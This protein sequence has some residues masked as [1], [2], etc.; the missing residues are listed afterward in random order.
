MTTDSSQA[1]AGAFEKITV[2]FEDLDVYGMVHHGKYPLLFERAFMS[3]LTRM[4]YPSDPASGIRE[5]MVQVVRSMQLTYDIPITKF[6]EI[7]VQFW[8]DHAGDT[9]FTHKFVILSSDRT[10]VHA[11]GTRGMVNLDARTLRPA[12]LTP[13]LLE[14]SRPLMSD[15]LLVALEA[16][17]TPSASPKRAAPG[18]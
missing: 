18:V 8:L 6:G 4:G 2:Q 10:V 9:S 11:S 13:G 17:M 16:R 3:Y 7:H 1:T 12:P 15:D 5:G 14:Y